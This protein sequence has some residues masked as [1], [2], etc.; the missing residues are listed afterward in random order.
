MVGSCFRK[1]AD[2]RGFD[3]RVKSSTDQLHN[4]AVQGP[5]SRETLAKIIWTPKLQT[6]LEDLKWFRF[7]IGRIGGEFGIPVMVSRTGYSGELG[8]EVFAH[9][10][11]CEA[12]WDCYCR[13]W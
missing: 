9:P 6:N 1:I 7:T 2:E 10:N 3:V 4:V 12:V 5:K 8:Y 11:D 13:G